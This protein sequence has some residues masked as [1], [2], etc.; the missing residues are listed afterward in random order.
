[1]IIKDFQLMNRLEKCEILKS[2]GYTY[3]PKT[4]KIFGVYGKEILSKNN[5]GYINISSRHIK[6][7]LRGHHFGW[8]MTYGNVDFN[9]LDHI[10]RNKLDNR[11]C[12]LRI[13]SIQEN[14]FNTNS[15]GV[16]FRENRKKWISRI[17][18]DK[19]TIH[20]GSFNNEEEAREAYLEAKQKYHII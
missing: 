8:Y 6:G 15:N 16:S 12:N 10:N 2:K 4:G 5:Y 1:M 20:L 19:K 17:T 18:K 13:V 7:Q 11:I 3:D 14:N 9:M